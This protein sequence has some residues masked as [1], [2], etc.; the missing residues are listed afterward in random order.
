MILMKNRILICGDRTWNDVHTIDVYI[1]KLPKNTVI[2]HGACRGAD[3]IAGERAK[4]HGL[5]VF[6]FP[7]NWRKYGRKAGP[8][9][10]Q[11][12][13]DNGKP[14][15][16]VAF[17]NNLFESK[18]TKDMIKRALKASIPVI[19]LSSGVNYNDFNEKKT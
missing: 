6:P 19:I 8:I 1:S 2:I 18:G 15:L 16:V 10:N 11:N 7:A 9:R 12:M 14:C 4:I 17:H 5:P 13:I 3:T